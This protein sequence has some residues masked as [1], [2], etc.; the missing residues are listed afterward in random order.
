MAASTRQ[1]LL[2]TSRGLFLRHGLDGVS[3]RALTAAADAN[4]AAVN[5]YF[6]S[7]SGLVRAVLLEAVA[8]LGAHWER[9]LLAAGP[10]GAVPRDFVAALARQPEDS[11][12]IAR[13]LTG[14]DSPHRRLLAAELADHLERWVGAL[15][16]RRPD[17][18]RAELHFELLRTLGS[19]L[20]LLPQ[21]GLVERLGA[22]RYPRRSP[23]AAIDRLASTLLPREDGPPDSR[24][25]P[26]PS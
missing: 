1:R 24:P 15:L 13:V 9:V 10:S 26:E 23:D 6:G 19:A 11:A 20:F 4:L 16:P 7:R 2:E 14:P 22:G 25:S 18:D 12:L 3:V 17:L 5:Y 21:P 8:G